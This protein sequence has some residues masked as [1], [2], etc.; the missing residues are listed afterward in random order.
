M[1]LEVLRIEGRANRFRAFD[2]RPFKIDLPALNKW[3]KKKSPFSVALPALPAA[4]G[5]G[6]SIVWKVRG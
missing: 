2:L 3:F 5:Q 6:G 1:N 4:P